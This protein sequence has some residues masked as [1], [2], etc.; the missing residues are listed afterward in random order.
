MARAISAKR[1][2]YDR[3]MLPERQRRASGIS[4][5]HDPEKVCSGFPKSQGATKNLA[6]VCMGKPS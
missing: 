3:T 4:P 1:A 6:R 5:P 2:G